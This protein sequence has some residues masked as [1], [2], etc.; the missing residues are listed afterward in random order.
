[1]LDL[2]DILPSEKKP[3][4]II[5]VSRGN[6][7]KDLIGA[8]M[9]PDVMNKDVHI[10]RKLPYGKLEEGEGSALFTCSVISNILAEKYLDV[11]NHHIFR[12]RVRT[13]DPGAP[14]YQLYGFRKVASYNPRVI[15]RV[16]CSKPNYFTGKAIDTAMQVP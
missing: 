2:D 13:Y 8:F 16:G 3:K 1:M 10:K 12:S 15:T 7:M 9:D 5:V 11:T 6:F 4:V 14:T